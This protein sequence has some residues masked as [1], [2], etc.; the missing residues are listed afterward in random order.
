MIRKTL[1]PGLA[2]GLLL[3][4][5]GC[6][7]VKVTGQPRETTYESPP[8][9]NEE[10]WPE[11]PVFEEV[12]GTGVFYL[13]TFR[14]KDLGPGYDICRVGKRWYWPYKGHWFTA[15]KWRG[16]WGFATAVPDNF[17]IIP[18]KHPRHRIAKLHPGYGKK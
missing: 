2:C 3:A 1:A 7:R 4:A 6:W 14:G 9:L 15:K 10:G 5:A 16:P 8:F 12:P 11:E 13:K 18:E 17:L